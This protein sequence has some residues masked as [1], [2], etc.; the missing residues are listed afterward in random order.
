MGNTL[1]CMGCSCGANRDELILFDEDRQK[2]PRL[3]EVV[4]EKELSRILSTITCKSAGTEADGGD[5]DVDALQSNRSKSQARV[6]AVEEV[7]ETLDSCHEVLEAEANSSNVNNGNKQD[8]VSLNASPIHE[9]KNHHYMKRNEDLIEEINHAVE[10]GVDKETRSQITS[11]QVAER[12]TSSVCGHRG[13]QGLP[14]RTQ[15]KRVNPIENLSEATSNG[16]ISKRSPPQVEYEQRQEESRKAPSNT[17]LRVKVKEKKEAQDLKETRLRQGTRLVSQVIT[18]L[19]LT[20]TARQV[21]TRKAH[22]N[23]VT[24]VFPDVKD[25]NLNKLFFPPKVLDP[26]RVLKAHS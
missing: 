19:F 17:A 10:K 11:Y 24:V 26:P 1:A 2:T 20:L 14:R 25:K 7:L 3:K 23:S 13:F 9:S 15:S 4:S 6:H 18:S 16:S 5:R 21:L 12:V 22:S 8:D